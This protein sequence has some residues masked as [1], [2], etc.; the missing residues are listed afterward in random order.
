MINHREDVYP[1][2]VDL[3]LIQQF[4]NVNAQIISHIIQEENV[5]RATHQVIGMHSLNNVFH[6]PQ[7][8][9]ITTQ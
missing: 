1:A 3:L 6:A 8:H 9:I 4:L 2:Q 7:I 5:Y